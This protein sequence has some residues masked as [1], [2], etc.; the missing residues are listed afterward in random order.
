VGPSALEAPEIQLTAA[1]DVQGRRRAQ[2]QLNSEGK[3]ESDAE[4]NQVN[5]TLLMSKIVL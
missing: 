1:W 3:G 4:E 5:Q 2:A